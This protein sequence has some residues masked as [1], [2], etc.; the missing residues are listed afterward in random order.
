MKDL[1]IVSAFI[2]SLIFITTIIFFAL[3]KSFA[4]SGVSKAWHQKAVVLRHTNFI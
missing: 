3:S 2:L 1:S 4:A